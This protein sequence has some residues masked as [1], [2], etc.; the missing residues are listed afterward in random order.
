MAIQVFKLRLE[1]ITLRLESKIFLDH[2]IN[3]HAKVRK[4]VLIRQRGCRAYHWHG[5]SSI[6]DRS[7]AML[8]RGS[9]SAAHRES[10]FLF[11]PDKAASGHRLHQRVSREFWHDPV[12]NQMIIEVRGVRLV[13]RSSVSVSSSGDRLDGFHPPCNRVS[14]FLSASCGWRRVERFSE[15]RWVERSSGSACEFRLRFGRESLHNKSR[16]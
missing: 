5:S 8:S 16:L 6:F 7:S 13:K 14:I 4:L 2:L 3:K 11:D 10:T 12:G 9:L 1:L 15:V